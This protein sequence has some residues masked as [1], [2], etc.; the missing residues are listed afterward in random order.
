MT[1]GVARA[2]L[3]LGEHFSQTI[4]GTSYGRSGLSSNNWDSA[5]VARDQ[6]AQNVAFAGFLSYAWSG[7]DMGVSSNEMLHFEDTYRTSAL[8]FNSGIT[9]PY[10][11]IQP[12][13]QTL[14]SGSDVGFTVFRAGTA[15]T[16]Y[17]WR[18]NGNNVPGATNSALN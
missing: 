11:L 9:A 17:Q 16:T 15:P 10:I 14:P 3:M 8:P 1:L 5:L 12:Q 2:K 13:S 7:N 18:F 6:A 4:S